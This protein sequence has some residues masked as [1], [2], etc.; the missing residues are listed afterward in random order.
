MNRRILN[1]E[2]IF[3]NRIFFILF[4][5]CLG[6][7]LRFELE[8][9]NL[10]LSLMSLIFTY[11]L[12]KFCLRQYNRYVI[13]HDLQII[14]Q[15]NVKDFSYI[16]LLFVILT[17]L[18]TALI[19]GFFAASIRFSI[20]TPK[21]RL[22]EQ[23]NDIYLIGQVKQFEMRDNGVRI[24]MKNVY[25]SNYYQEKLN[26]LDIGLVR[27]HLRQKIESNNL[28]GEWIFLKATLIPPPP[29]AFPNTFDFAQYAFFKGIG[30]IGYTIQRPIILN[31]Q[32]NNT[33][34]FKQDEL[35]KL[36]KII[37]TRIQNVM[38]EPAAGITAAILVGENSQMNSNDYYALRVA[39]LAHIIAI[40]GMHV[41]V[42]VAIA[43]FC[44]RAILLYLIP[45]ITNY[46]IALYFSVPKISAILSICLSTFYVL[47][48]NAPV[49]AQR[50]LIT[51]SILMLCIVYDK[52]VNAI[53]S[54]CLAAIIMLIITPEALFSPGLQM[55][56][57]ACF[58]L[59]STFELLDKSF[60]FQSKYLDYFFKLIMSSI[61]A[62]A[63]T[64]PFII[65]HFNQFAPYGILANLVCV[66]LSDFILMPFGMASMI[67]MF[68]GIEKYLLIPM[69]Y[70]IDF[71]L[72]I[73]YK[74]SALP[75]A[76]IH[77]PSFSNTG[78]VLFSS[79]LF[80]LCVSNSK[81]IRMTG[82]LMM[83]SSC[84]LIQKYDNAILIVSKKTFAIRY[85]KI[86][87][88]TDTRFVFSSKQKDRFVHDVWQSKIG[89]H[90]FRS[91]S[92]SKLKIPFCTHH[93]CIANDII[94]LNSKFSLRVH[95]LCNQIQPRIFVN[96]YDNQKCETAKQNI[97]LENL[98]KT[99]IIY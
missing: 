55:S 35:N 45:L 94:I 58:A 7:G 75:F 54:L 11:V 37:T 15:Q 12:Y 3:K 81:I 10:F 63:A 71:M 13:W 52:Y 48:A 89:K 50:A 23:I 22:I 6:I 9:Q 41:V 14:A 96:M 73:A 1:L 39:G 29:P 20:M 2:N 31:S 72:W 57:A 30:A 97:T 32:I 78:I 87:N 93:L 76:D 34:S 47:L 68:F 16:Y 70:G 33:F 74:V 86:S 67:G 4:C 38:T 28:I 36:R 49:S 53:Q 95:E 42:V 46:Q 77:V 90:N 69:Q 64:A 56:F 59:L 27:I 26:S 51:S 18:F 17:M 43:F 61:A 99:T 91:E 25:E 44:V 92:L 19:I 84:S 66:P 85:D 80:I 83:L 88:S 24:Y 82:I 21:N 62:S 98:H 8:V 60:K 65:Y 40:S 5:L 79:G